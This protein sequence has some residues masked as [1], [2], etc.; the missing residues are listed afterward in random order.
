MRIRT[1]IT[2]L[3][4]VVLLTSLA[5][6]QNSARESF[7]YSPKSIADMGTATDGF[8][9]PWLIDTSAHGTEGP[10]ILASNVFSYGD[11]SYAVPDTGNMFQVTRVNSWGD[12]QRYKRA[13]ASTW[14]NTP[15]NIYWFSYLVDVKA[16]PDK[17]AFFGVKLI[18]TDTLLTG[19]GEILSLGKSCGQTASVFSCGS[20]AGT[21][22][23]GPA[24]DQST[25]PVDVGPVWLVV[26]INMSGDTLCRTFMWVNPDPSVEPDTTLAVVKRNSEMPDGFN[27]IAL[28]YAMNVGATPLQVIIDEIRLA[29]NYADLTLKTPVGTSARESFMYSPKSI[30]DMGTA[31]D[32]FGGPWLIDTSAHGTEGPGILA[33]N[34]FSYGD[35][36][37]AVP[38]TG[39]MFQVTRVNSWGDSQRYKRALAST[40]SNTPGNIYWFSYLVDVKA[41]P[42]K[43]AFFGVKL[44][45]TDTLLTGK[46]EILSLG[47]S[48]G[49]TASVFSC[50]SGAGT[51]W[52]GPAEDQSTV[53]VDVG[54]VWLVV[55][56]NMSGDT[57]CR[58]FM[59][60]N[61]DPSVEPDTTLAV[62]KRNSEMPDGFNA[63]ALEYA[64]NVGATPLQVII[65]E[66]RIGKSYTDLSSPVTG[67]EQE[68]INQ[69]REFALSQNY[70]NPFNPSTVISYTLKSTGNARLLVYDLLGREVVVLVNGVQAAGLHTVSFSAARLTSGVY[71]YR[72]ENAGT[73]ITKKMMLL[74]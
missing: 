45:S 52:G 17:D 4:I 48:C 36:S 5:L 34:V 59:W 13:L 33:S 47:K 65:D 27:A 37:Y 71:F 40:W 38:D 21:V 61:P 19:K 26:R 2:S 32:G 12:S 60:V 29:T 6:S 55:R 51:V 25:V 24:E 50:G 31:T 46:G 66:I 54:P 7:M 18:S 15:G 67:V 72:L 35:L 57:L 16:V 43:D 28:E 8:G 62:V 20:G 14:S 58:T 30:A 70:P 42:D 22:W 3:A 69:P 44:I 64:M 23:G 39:N 1:L 10:G 9:G 56:I 63:I 49:Q 74:K 41:V 73:T 68:R 11:L 53:P